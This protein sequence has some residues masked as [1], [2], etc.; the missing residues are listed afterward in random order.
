MLFN[1]GSI[2]IIIVILLN[3]TRVG[4]IIESYI[5]CA[6]DMIIN[7]VYFVTLD[8][9]RPMRDIQYL[10]CK[11]VSPIAIKYNDW[12]YDVSH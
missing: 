8:S 12:F 7:C 6:Y 2:L 5:Y 10:S 11:H 4:Y 9:L 3:A 1:C